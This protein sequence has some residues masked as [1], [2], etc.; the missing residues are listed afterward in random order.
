MTVS[1]DLA[2]ILGITYDALV[3]IV[4]DVTGSIE[5]SANAI[6][7]IWEID[8]EGEWIVWV[9]TG[10][11]A[12]GAGLYLLLV[13]SMEEIIENY[14]EPK[15]GR[16]GGRRGQRRERERRLNRAGQ[17]RVFFRGGFP[18]IDHAIAN[19]IPGRNFIA[20][21][22][23]GPGEYLFWS[24]IN[25][26]D[27]VLWYWLLIEATE[28]FTTT[29]QSGLLE[30]GHCGEFNN[31]QCQ[32]RVGE[33]DSFTQD[34]LWFSAETLIG[35]TQRNVDVQNNGIIALELNA[36]RAGTMVIIETVWTL[37]TDDV[38]GK[39]VIKVGSSIHTP[40]P[41][42]TPSSPIERTSVITLHEGQKTVRL[43]SQVVF[44]HDM[45][46]M[47]CRIVYEVLESVSLFD[48]TMTARCACAT[49]NL[50]LV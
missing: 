11:E 27:R 34:P 38:E 36:L 29:W 35:L 12:L 4:D 7:D 42:G 22:R 44:G 16:R 28:V 8:C 50:Y 13:P 49:R 19:R 39:T 17:R 15:A 43:V 9:K 10:L 32:F 2:Y 30:S 20:G 14:L 31:G 23:I 40:T 21:R 37:E 25:N 33:R 24:G 45:N 41:G 46:T 5:N 1:G 47:D 48:M 3:D 26:A 6:V 18:D